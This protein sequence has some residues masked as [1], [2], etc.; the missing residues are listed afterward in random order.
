L[1]AFAHENSNKHFGPVPFQ[2][3]LQKRK[4]KENEKPGPRYTEQP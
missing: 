2:S 1:V 3:S 4:H